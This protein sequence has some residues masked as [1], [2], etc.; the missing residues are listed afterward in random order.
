MMG[1][2]NINFKNL[3]SLGVGVCQIDTSMMIIES[4]DVHQDDIM[5]EIDE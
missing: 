3:T 4:E 1:N 5:L 2:Q